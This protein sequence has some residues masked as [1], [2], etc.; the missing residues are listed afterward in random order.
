VLKDG[1]QEDTLRELAA[2]LVVRPNQMVVLGCMPDRPRSLGHFLFTEPEANSDRLLQKVLLLWASEGVLD[3]LATARPAMA[4][5]TPAQN[6]V[7]ATAQPPAASSKTDRSR[8]K[9]E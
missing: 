9:T 1:Q 6:A 2:T 8:R 7:P 3:P 5:S 4:G